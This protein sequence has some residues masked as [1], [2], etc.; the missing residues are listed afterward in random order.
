MRNFKADMSKNKESKIQKSI[1]FGDVSEMNQ[2]EEEVLIEEKI[3]ELKDLIL[4]NDDVNTF[5]HVINQLT[6]YCE[7]SMIQAEQCAH[8][9]HNNGKCQ[10]KRGEFESLKPICETLL[11][12]GLSAVI[13]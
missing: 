3:V 12:K 1:Y 13:E 11:E 5:D 2:T 8:I 4:Y 6:K 10:I 7:H 9:V